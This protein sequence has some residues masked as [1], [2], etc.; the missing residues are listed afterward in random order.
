MDN[1]KINIDLSQAPSLR[2]SPF[3]GIVSSQTPGPPAPT[4]LDIGQLR[5]GLLEIVT[6]LQDDMATATRNCLEQQ[7]QQLNDLLAQYFEQTDPRFNALVQQSLD[8]EVVVDSLI[9]LVVLDA[10]LNE[11]AK[12]LHQGVLSKFLM[13]DLSNVQ[14]ESGRTQS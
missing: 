13:R 2:G 7:N 9:K 12:L 14:E 4:G 11:E 8:L 6:Q 1:Q 10:D 5:Q 3:S